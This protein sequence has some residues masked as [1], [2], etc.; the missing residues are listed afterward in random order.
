MR[1]VVSG[2]A[3]K[4]GG[5]TPLSGWTVE[6]ENSGPEE[7]KVHFERNDDE[8]EEI[9]FKATIDDGELKVSISEHGTEDESK[10]E[11]EDD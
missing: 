5:A 3:V 4:F 8:E 1:I 10:E 7:V 9:E 2:S 6:L 11:S